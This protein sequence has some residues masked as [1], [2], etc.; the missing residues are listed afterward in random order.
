MEHCKDD[1]HVLALTKVDCVREA[2]QH[3]TAHAFEDNRVA[4]RGTSNLLDRIPKLPQELF[5]EAAAFS[6]STW[7]ARR[8][9]TRRLIVQVA[10]ELTL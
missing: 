7:A 8:K 10:L 6:S 5:A 1:Q 9:T 3:C 2:A 4:L